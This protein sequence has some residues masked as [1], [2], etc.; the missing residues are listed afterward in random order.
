VKRYW[1]VVEVPHSGLGLIEIMNEFLDV[2]LEKAPE[3]IIFE[4]ELVCT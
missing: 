2:R 1:L 3:E 4:A